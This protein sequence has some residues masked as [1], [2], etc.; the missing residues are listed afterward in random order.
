MFLPATQLGMIVDIESSTFPLGMQ[1]QLKSYGEDMYE[2][3]QRMDGQETIRAVNR[4]NGE[5]RM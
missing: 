5:Q 3:R 4:Y 1:E 2:W